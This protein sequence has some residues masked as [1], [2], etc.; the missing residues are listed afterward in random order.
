MLSRTRSNARSVQSKFTANKTLQEHVDR[1]EGD[2][3]NDRVKEIRLGVAMCSVTVLRYMTG[4]VSTLPISVVTRIGKHHDVISVLVPLL[5][6]PPWVRENGQRGE[7]RE[8]SQWVTIQPSDRF[9]LSNIDAQVC[10]TTNHLYRAN[11]FEYCV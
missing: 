3:F 9:K 6:S 1:S 2:L 7:R 5:E 10:A 11:D 4:A 8:G